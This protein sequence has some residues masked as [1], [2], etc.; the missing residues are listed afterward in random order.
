VETTN[1]QAA[2][3]EIPERERRMPGIFTALEPLEWAALF[4]FCAGFAYV[5][6]GFYFPD[7]DVFG[8][9]ATIV[10]RGSLFLARLMLPLIGI[11]CV[12]LYL[13]VRA[14]LIESAN[15]WLLV[16]GVLMG[17]VV[18]YL[19]AF[20]YFYLSPSKT[21]L[22]KY[23]AYLQLKPPLL[24][25][26]AA[27][28]AAGEKRIVFFG[29]STTA[30][31]DSHGN[32]WPSMIAEGLSNPHVKVLNQAREWYTTNHSLINYELN[33]RPCRPDVIVVM[34]AINDLFVNFASNDLTLG[35][36]R[37]DY[38]HFLGPVSSLVNRKSFFE[39]VYEE[40]E[41]SWYASRKEVVTTQ[42]FPGLTAFRRNLETMMDLASRDGTAV[43]LMTEPYLYRRDMSELELS[44]LT[45]LNFEASGPER[46]WSLQ[47]ALS[48]MEQYNNEVRAVAKERNCML[49][50]LER[51][52]PKSLDYIRDDVHYTDRAFPLIRDTVL[53]SI[54]PILK[55]RG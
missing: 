7:P 4:L 55:A 40:V 6:A 36:Y 45:M 52:V 54:T 43:V 23:H 49:I 17:A 20:H 50:D 19:V 37:Q 51:V 34:H 48:G 38:G 18:M 42:D 35:G 11:G 2:N 25:D 12:A 33:V 24:D 28:A 53:G 8:A 31:P 30:W 15:V 10:L 41:R 5:Y 14:K 9:H 46:K 29:G 22:D 39:S 27:P 13:G 32:D 47:T 16:G 44:K 3:V 26:C 21:P 1:A